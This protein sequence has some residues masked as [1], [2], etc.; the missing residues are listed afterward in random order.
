MAIK[1]TREAPPKPAA[2]QHN[3]AAHMAR[4]ASSV[5]LAIRKARGVAP[6]GPGLGLLPYLAGFA[7]ILSTEAAASSD[8]NS[9]WP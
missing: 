4:L 8:V 6:K 5:I 1:K 7:S 9:T 3:V 2:P